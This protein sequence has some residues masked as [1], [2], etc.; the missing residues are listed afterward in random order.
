M[1][2]SRSCRE[3]RIVGGVAGLINLSIDLVWFGGRSAVAPWHP[4]MSNGQCAGT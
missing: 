1:V 4:R 3:A 2:R